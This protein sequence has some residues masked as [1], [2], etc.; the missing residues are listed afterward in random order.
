MISAV[1]FQNFMLE[2]ITTH[3]I[4]CI[5]SISFQTSF[6]FPASKLHRSSDAGLPKPR[7]EPLTEPYF[8]SGLKLQKIIQKIREINSSYSQQRPLNELPV[9]NRI[10]IFRRY[11][12]KGEN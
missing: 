8:A 5:Y 6:F 11:I 1:I 2:N 7:N 9:V 3:E 10:R 4:I 12:S